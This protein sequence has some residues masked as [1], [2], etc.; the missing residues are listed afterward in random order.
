METVFVAVT[1]QR[2]GIDA[3]GTGLIIQLKNVI[4]R[5]AQRDGQN[6]GADGSVVVPFG[7]NGGNDEIVRVIAAGQE[8]TNQGLVIGD[9]GLGDSGVHQTQIADGAF[10]GGGAYGGT[11]RLADE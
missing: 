8:D 2:G 11:G 4:R 7:L 10:E 9:A 3:T 1:V 5:A 6:I